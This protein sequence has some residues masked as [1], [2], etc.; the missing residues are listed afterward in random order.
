[1]ATDLIFDLLRA[2]A[3]WWSGLTAEEQNAAFLAVRPGRG[4][5]YGRW[6]L[7]EGVQI[8]VT[9][10]W[11]RFEKGSLGP[12]RA[13][14]AFSAQLFERWIRRGIATASSYT[15]STVLVATAA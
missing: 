14:E 13:F 8:S 4:L 6:I 3:C 10:D 11:S 2:T 15:S 1:M 7:K 9:L 12:E 5:G